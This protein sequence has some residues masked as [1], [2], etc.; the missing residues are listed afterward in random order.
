MFVGGKKIASQKFDFLSPNYHASRPFATRNKKP[1]SVKV[2]KQKLLKDSFTP[3]VES[4]NVII[5]FEENEKDNTKLLFIGLDINNHTTGYSIANDEG[6]I[7]QC[8]LFS[9]AKLPKTNLFEKILFI[10]D[11]LHSIK[12]Q[13]NGENN[14]EN[15]KWVVG[16]KST[17]KHFGKISPSVITTS[18]QMSGIISYECYQ[19]VRYYF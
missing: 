17:P 2:K 8:G 12:L 9:Y 7:I 3:N 11:K 19:L 13:F 10:K 16:L 1:K 18:I 14:N 4:E 6:K 5:N 15:Y